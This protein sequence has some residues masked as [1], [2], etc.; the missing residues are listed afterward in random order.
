MEPLSVVGPPAALRTSYQDGRRRGEALAELCRPRI[1]RVPA[2]VFLAAGW[3]AGLAAPAL[4][5]G[6]VVIVAACGAASALNDRADVV[7]DRRNGRFERPLAAGV[8][9]DRHVA[10]VVVGAAVVALVAQ[11]ALPQPTAL[12]VTAG[13]LALAAA[14]ACEPV[15]LQRRGGVGLVALAAA[16]LVLPAGLAAGWVAMGR[17]APVAALGAGVLAHKDRRDEEGDRAAGKATVVVRVG[18]RGMA[19]R[20][21]GWAAAGVVALAVTAG[22]GW[23]CLPAVAVVAEL[24]A[25]ARH[26]HRSAG[27]TRA[28]VALVLT[29]AAVAVSVVTPLSG[30]GA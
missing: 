19:R 30:V 2:L 10:G 6:V 7:S 3:S 20:A 25:M 16:Y 26:G 14:C 21:A 11:A 24:V 15:A 12:V 23:W 17:L 22:P 18:V 1:A 13:A 29:A 9:G 5:A 4:V 8:L 27:W 28:R